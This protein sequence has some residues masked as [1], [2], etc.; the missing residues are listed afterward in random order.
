[1][2]RVYLITA[3]TCL[4]IISAFIFCFRLLGFTGEKEHLTVGFIYDND[5]STPERV[6]ICVAPPP[7]PP[8]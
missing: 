2:K 6:A 4:V 8:W 7:A 1:M 3:I 5:E